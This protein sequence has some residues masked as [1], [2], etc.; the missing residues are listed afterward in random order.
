MFKVALA[1]CCLSVPFFLG[2]VVGALYM[3]RHIDWLEKRK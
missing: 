3:T 2:V 1:A